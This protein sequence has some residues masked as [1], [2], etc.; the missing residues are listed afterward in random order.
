[1]DHVF[2]LAV[3]LIH[4]CTCAKNG[5]SCTSALNTECKIKC[6]V[7]GLVQNLTIWANWPRFAP[8]WPFLVRMR[9]NGHNT[10]SGVKF[11]YIELLL[12]S[13]AVSILFI[14]KIALTALRCVTG[15]LRC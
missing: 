3:Y 8:F 4:H 6:S 13:L 9:R 1:M 12:G 10:T 11:D 14:L 7:H 5:H 2:A 15:R